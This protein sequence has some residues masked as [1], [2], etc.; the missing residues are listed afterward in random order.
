VFTALP[1]GGRL[2]P[3]CGCLLDGCG[4]G[5]RSRPRCPCCR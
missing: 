1:D 2:D 4:D 5:E 3:R